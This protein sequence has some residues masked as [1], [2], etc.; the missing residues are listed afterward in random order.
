MELNNS[1]LNKENY[2]VIVDNS[3]NINLSLKDIS[4]EVSFVVLDNQE[5]N[6]NIHDFNTAN[7][8]TFYVNKFSKVNVKII[9]DNLDKKIAIKGDVKD[10][11]EINF[12]FADFSSNN[13]DLVSNVILEGE[14]SKGSFRFSSVANDKITKK[15]NVGFDQIGH[16]SSSEFIGYG[17]SLKTGEID[18]KGITHI[19]KNVVNAVADQ[20]I[21]VIL[22]DKESKAKASPTLRIDS[23]DIIA[24]HACAIGSLNEDHIF[25]LKTRGLDE[26]EA[27]RLITMGYLIPLE[28]YFDKDDKDKIDSYI[29]EN[30]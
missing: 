6:L 5:L 20:K 19:E 24:N 12:Y 18:A 13:L 30:F 29:K 25:Y 17:V 22:F 8:L 16:K 10:S 15:Y 9:N 14:N 23:D 27:R 3:L 21:K 1:I 26:S 7:Q 2:S 4:S 11:G 28:E